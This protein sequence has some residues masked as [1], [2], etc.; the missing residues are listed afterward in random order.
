M[1]K[2][3]TRKHDPSRKGNSVYARKEAFLKKHGGWGWEYPTKPWK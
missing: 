2:R 1:A 3:K